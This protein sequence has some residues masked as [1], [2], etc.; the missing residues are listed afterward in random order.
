MNSGLP[1][2]AV[3]P[4]PALP[5]LTRPA[6]RFLAAL[7]V[8]FALCVALRLHGSS[9]AYWTTHGYKDIRI[10]DAPSGLLLGSP[11]EVRSDEWLVWT[12]SILS[13]ARQEPSFPTF[14]PSLG[15]DKTPLLM[16]IPARHYTM[17]FRPQLW[18]Y[19]A[20]PFEWAFSWQWNFKIFAP[21]TA[22]FLLFWALTDGRFGLSVCGALL[23]GFS[24]FV[25]WW[26]S[27]PA[28]L[29]E[30][31]AC[32]AVC[33]VCAL[34]LFTPQPPWRRAWTVAAFMACFVNGLLCCYPAFEI[35]VVYLGACLVVGFVWQKGWFG[36]RA[37]G[38]LAGA[39]ALGAA[40]LAPWL[41]ECREILS[42]VAGTVYPGQRFCVG[43]GLPVYR[44]F[45]GLLSVGLT[46]KSCPPQLINI[47]EAANFYPLW[48]LPLAFGGVSLGAFLMKRNG[49]FREWI[50]ARAMKVVLS[51]YLLTLVLF[52]CVPFPAWLCSA[53]L[54]SRC[55]E[56]RNLVGLGLGGT[57]LLILSLLAPKPPIRRW[58][59]GAAMLVWAGWSLGMLPVLLQAQ[60]LMPKLL[61]WECLALL[62]I[63]AA[64][65]GYAWIAGRTHAAMAALLVMCALDTALSNPLCMGLPELL[66]SPTLNRVAAMSKAEP[67][68][69]WAVYNSVLG[70]ELIKASGAPLINGARIVPDFALID[71]FDPAG[72]HRDAYNRYAHLLLRMHTRADDIPVQVYN[73]VY[74]TILLN[75]GQAAEIFP[76]MKYVVVPFPSPELEAEGFE[77]AER[78]PDNQMCIY[79]RTAGMVTER[80]PSP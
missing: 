31:I 69:Q 70:L 67:S 12:P 68:A 40:L 9:S 74:C 56:Q 14:N 65:L 4:A 34:T 16:G 66:R 45:S 7:A 10:H 59:F 77:L 44:L 58:P 48:L 23:I 21:L 18:A 73:K 27:S 61:T 8:L 20:L 28:M 15:P 13:Q 75:P 19:F 3:S 26:L 64:L 36:W 78:F 39:V 17:L 29:P 57:L 41:I 38:R 24:G 52:A 71:K 2:S 62:E 46:E 80:A 5:A 11:R 76:R 43:G 32:W 25:Q 49:S 55:L 33:V 60:T 6:W 42:A 1:E 35:P 54:L 63:V 53:T 22:V 37:M 50:A 30:M 72:K 47:C 79:R 51:L